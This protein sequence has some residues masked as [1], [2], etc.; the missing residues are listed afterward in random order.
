MV[1]CGDFS[2]HHV[3]NFLR[4][5][6]CSTSK[7]SAGVTFFVC[8]GA[9]WLK[10]GENKILSSFAIRHVSDPCSFR[11]FTVGSSETLSYYRL[12]L[13]CA[14]LKLL[15]P[16]HGPKRPLNP[17]L[18]SKPILSIACSTKMSLLSLN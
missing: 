14:F 1:G 2:L 15:R 6:P 13:K 3:V 17:S 8:S 16:N 5:E 4:V 11:R 18:H 10:S 7:R 12:L 9:T